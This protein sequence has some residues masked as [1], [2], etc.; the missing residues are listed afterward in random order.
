[1][2]P[3]PWDS[4]G[5][6]TG[7][8]FHFLLQCMKVKSESKVTQS[9][10]T[11][12]DPMDCTLSGSSI[13]GI[14]QGRVQKCGAIAFS[15]GCM[16][17]SKASGKLVKTWDPGTLAPR[18]GDFQEGKDERKLNCIHCWAAL[19]FLQAPEWKFLSRCPSTLVLILLA[20][21]PYCSNRKAILQ[22]LSLGCRH[23]GGAPAVVTP[24]G[25][26]AGVDWLS[27]N[28]E[29]PELPILIQTTQTLGWLDNMKLHSQWEAF[30]SQPS[31]N[32]DKCF[33]FPQ[34]RPGWGTLRSETS[35]D[36]GECVPSLMLQIDLGDSKTLR[37]LQSLLCFLET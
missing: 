25:S 15:L 6:N 20:D 28:S 35:L 21:L 13:H 1:M 5:K 12:S 36:A 19:R 16:T 32:L 23:S 8:G 11:L 17:H 26:H 22:A 3:S 37:E 18:L 4:P 7:V 9:C 31:G 29:S 27:P 14:F 34:G 33:M 10:P 24:G 2:L 30:S